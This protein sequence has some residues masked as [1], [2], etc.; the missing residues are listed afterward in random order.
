MGVS[1]TGLSGESLS[2][3]GGGRRRAAAA[4]A[5]GVVICPGAAGAI[6][7]V[8]YY[9]RPPRSAGPR[10]VP[11]ELSEVGKLAEPPTQLPGNEDSTDSSVLCSAAGSLPRLLKH[12]MTVPPHDYGD[13]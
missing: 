10:Y 1:I 2:A 12:V 8:V 3:A 6:G 4:V 11:G 7:P 13:R 9:R 5:G